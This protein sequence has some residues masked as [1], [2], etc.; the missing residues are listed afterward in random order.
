MDEA[1]DMVRCL[2]VSAAPSSF[3]RWPKMAKKVTVTDMATRTPETRFPAKL[4]SKE[5]PTSYSA[6]AL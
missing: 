6:A 4:T 1:M 3:C 5:N 2:T